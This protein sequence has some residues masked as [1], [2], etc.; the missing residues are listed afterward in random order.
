MADEERN[1]ARSHAEIEGLRKLAKNPYSKD[2]RFH[3]ESNQFVWV[4]NLSGDDANNPTLQGELIQ[5]C[6]TLHGQ[7]EAAGIENP[8]NHG[9]EWHTIDGT[10]MYGAFITFPATD[11][12][13][14]IMASL[15]GI[16]EQLTERSPG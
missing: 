4:E 2:I 6:N 12:N 15:R 8:Q 7:M 16:M 10:Q 13:K 1:S 3:E 11:K 14:S 5:A 9:V